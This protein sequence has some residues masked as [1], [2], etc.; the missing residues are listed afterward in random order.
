VTTALMLEEMIGGYLSGLTGR[1]PRADPKDIEPIRR[2][3]R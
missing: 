3:M 2:V 1:T